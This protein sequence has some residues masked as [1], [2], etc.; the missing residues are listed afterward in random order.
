M[1]YAWAG[2]ARGLSEGIM[3]AMERRLRMEQME[4][5]RQWREQQ[6]ELQRAASG[7]VDLTQLF[8]MAGVPTEHPVLL[9]REAVGPVVGA[10]AG[11]LFSDP[12]PQSAVVTQDIA[13]YYR[14]PPGAVGQP[15]D[16]W[17]HQMEAPSPKSALVDLGRFDP[18]LAGI[19]VTASDV[20]SNLNRLRPGM[21]WDAQ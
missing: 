9:P 2:A 13:D 19:E 15:L 11:R 21:D 8:H 12:K 18:T 20:L 7:P 4:Q 5:E 3:A 10:A 17:R 14:L 6:L 1:P 16:V